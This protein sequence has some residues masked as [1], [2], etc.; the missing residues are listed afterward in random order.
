MGV[1]KNGWL[2][3]WGSFAERLRRSYLSGLSYGF[4]AAS[5]GQDV[6]L[7]PALLLCTD[8]VGRR[9]F[10]DL[11]VRPVRGERLRAEV[12]RQKG[13]AS[14]SSVS[15]GAPVNAQKGQRAVG[16]AYHGVVVALHERQEGQ[17]G[18]RH[19]GP[20]KRAH[21]L[22]ALGAPFHSPRRSPLLRE[23][24][25]GSRSGSC[26]SESDGRERSCRGAHGPLM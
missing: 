12:H 22:G 10:Q 15:V 2:S 23:T 21:C 6:V 11:V 14:S 26:R 1:G 9:V 5:V 18:L 25:S 19:V 17:V 4:L 24:P 7:A 13:S 3:S 8:Q 20:R 16:G